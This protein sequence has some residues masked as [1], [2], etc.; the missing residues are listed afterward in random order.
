MSPGVRWSCLCS[1]LYRA[2]LPA[3]AA[4]DGPPGGTMTYSRIY[5]AAV[6]MVDR[7][8]AEGRAGKVVFSDPNATLTYGELQAS[9]NRLA[10]L[11]SAYGLPRESRVALLLHDTIDFP[12]VF[13]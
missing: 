12:V 13:W 1:R 9:C 3:R 2:Q 10:N 11:L 6:D 8:V 4:Q 5:N 7:N